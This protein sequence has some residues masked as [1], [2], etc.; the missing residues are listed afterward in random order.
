[1]PLSQIAAVGSAAIALV[2]LYLTFQQRRNEKAKLRLDVYPKRVAV[3][4]STEEF[5][6]RVWTGSGDVPTLLTAFQQGKREAQ[7]LFDK[8]LADYLDSLYDGVSDHFNLEMKLEI[9]GDRLAFAEKRALQE[10]VYGSRH[11]L[12]QQNMHLKEHFAGYLDLSKLP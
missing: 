8:K 3:F 1:M 6:A 12:A 9:Q 5:L 7:F 4:R 2:A 11:W 10:R